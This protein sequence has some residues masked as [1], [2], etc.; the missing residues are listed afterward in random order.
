MGIDRGHHF[1][2]DLE[3]GHFDAPTVGSGNAGS[4]ISGSQ[5][6]SGGSM[7]TSLGMGPVTGLGDQNPSMGDENAPM[8]RPKGAAPIQ[9]PKFSAPINVDTDELFKKQPPGQTLTSDADG[10]QSIMA[11]P[12]RVAY[13]HKVLNTT[14]M[15]LPKSGPDDTEHVG[16]D[17]YNRVY[18]EEKQYRLNYDDEH[19]HV[20]PNAPPDSPFA[21]KG[22]SD[23]LKRRDAIIGRINADPSVQLTSSQGRGYS[24]NYT[25]MDVDLAQGVKAQAD[26]S[27]K[28]N[29]PG[30]D[31]PERKEY[32]KEVGKALDQGY[33]GK[34]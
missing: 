10:E 11:Q 16:Q 14:G 5:A 29:T 15:A 21:A 13:R 18:R 17:E 19:N 20:D 26:A 9:I 25:D 31:S 22:V 24:P 28:A 1:G 34:P 3:T 8:Q 6:S 4:D 32:L 2:G 12:D 7:A 27:K 30:S 33:R 23:Y